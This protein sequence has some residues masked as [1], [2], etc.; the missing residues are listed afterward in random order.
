MKR[1]QRSGTQPKNHPDAVIVVAVG[2]MIVVTKSGARVVLIVVPRTAPNQRH[3][4]PD[5]RRRS[6]AS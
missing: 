6:M 5:H 4:V 1:G 2:R 3:S